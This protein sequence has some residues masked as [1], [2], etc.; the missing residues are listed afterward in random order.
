VRLPKRELSE[1]TIRPLR[2]AFYFWGDWMGNEMANEY[3]RCERCKTEYRPQASVYATH[4]NSF[5]LVLASCHARAR[6]WMSWIGAL[7]SPREWNS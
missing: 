4:P 6:K 1:S 3:R 5:T 2:G 7:A